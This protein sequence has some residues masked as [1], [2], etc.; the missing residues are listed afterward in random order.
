MKYFVCSDIHGEF[1]GFINSLK[2][3]GFEEGCSNHRV[4]V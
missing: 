3:N 2:E 1:Q 4:V